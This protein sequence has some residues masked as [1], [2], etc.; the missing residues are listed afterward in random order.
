[1]NRLLKASIFV[2]FYLSSPIFAENG[3]QSFSA[4]ELQQ[5]AKL[6]DAAL[7]ANNGYAIV[8]SLTTEVGPRMGGSPGDALAVRWAVDKF[9]ALGFDKVW[10]EPVTFPS[11]QRGLEQ[12]TIV[13][14]YR[15]KLFITALGNSVSTSES[16]LKAQIVQFD[17][18]EDLKAAEAG[19]V[20]GKIVFISQKMARYRS[21]KGYGEAVPGR[22]NG[23]SEAAKKGAKA[24]I[25]RSIGTD[26][27]RM[28]HTGH[29]AYEDGVHKIPAAAMSNPDADLLMNML[30]RGKPVELQLLI[31][32]G[33][34]GEYTSHNVIGEITGST[35][36]DEV[37][38]LGAHL[39]SWD[40]G[41]GAIDDGAGVAITMAAAA[42][43]KQAGIKPKRTIRV[44]LFANEE[45]GLFGG[46][47]YAKAHQNELEKHIVG[48]ESDFGAG[49][50][51]KFSTKFKPEALPLIE[52][53]MQ[54]L[55]PLG[56]E[57]GTNKATGGPDLIA[58]RDMGMSVVNLH[59]DG[60]DYFD[61]HHTP[62]DTLDKIDP[63]SLTQNVAAY[64]AFA[65]LMAMLE[66]DVGF[67]PPVLET[68]QQ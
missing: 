38:L 46:K 17:T 49:K 2:L 10:T 35:Y 7:V 34:A 13:A 21:G 6:R 42:L 36:P 58:S 66:G 52:Q 32:A 9:K 37:V 23:A 19:D 29:M 24:V 22:R 56:I 60:S 54:V 27:D 67:Y 16:G 8:E 25:I 14:P 51:Y 65:Y 48:A 64:T 45:Q 20:E 30:A 57:Y 53:I 28:P 44:V 61:Y 12:A 31:T 41:T 68:Q 1:M 40:L 11:W 15:H 26:S 59:Q 62:N 4:E 3:S 39:D 43:I 50:I 5:A 18:L 63:E 55:T 47:A 33:A